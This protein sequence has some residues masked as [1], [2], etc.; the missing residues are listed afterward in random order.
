MAGA[1]GAAITQGGHNATALLLLGGMPP[2]LCPSHLEQQLLAY[3]LQEQGLALTVNYMN[4]APDF[5]SKLDTLASGRGPGSSARAFS[6]DHRWFDPSRQI[7]SLVD[8]LV[9]V[10]EVTEGS[11]SG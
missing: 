10:T 5:S 11:A 7:T 4:P 3:R 9:A 2:F 6:D 8:D 1:C